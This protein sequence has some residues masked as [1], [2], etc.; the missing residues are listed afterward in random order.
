MMFLVLWWMHE[1]NFFL[2]ISGTYALANT[3]DYNRFK[4]ASSFPVWVHSACC[5]CELHC[6]IL[7][8]W[9]NGGQCV[10]YLQPGDGGGH[11]HRRPHLRKLGKQLALSI[12]PM[13][14]S[15]RSG[16]Y[17]HFV[18]WKQVVVLYIKINS[19]LNSYSIDCLSV[20]PLFVTSS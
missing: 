6:G 11:W 14:H 12:N 16:F 4:R 10:E 9:Q 20:S 5:R 18:F 15:Y 7:R 17:D 8:Q 13:F 2:R 1:F 19:H 3:Q